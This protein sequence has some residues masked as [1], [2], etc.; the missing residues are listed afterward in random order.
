MKS[1]GRLPAPVLFGLKDIGSRWAIITSGS[2]GAGSGLRMQART[3]PIHT[4]TTIAKGGS[5]TKDTGTVRTTTTAIGATMVVGMVIAITT[6]GD[7][8]T[9][10]KISHVPGLENREAWAPTLSGSSC[11]R[12]T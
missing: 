5:I 1:P 7:T 3:G 2:A 8:S 6:S 10:T 9:K 11:S 4:T 12:E